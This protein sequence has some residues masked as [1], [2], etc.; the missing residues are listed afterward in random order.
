MMAKK[1]ARKKKTPHYEI[2][3]PAGLI[4]S[5]VDKQARRE[6]GWPIDDD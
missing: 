2:A 1:R 5:G 4:I 3:P 6:M